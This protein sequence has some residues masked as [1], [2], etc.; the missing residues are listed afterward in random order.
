MGYGSFSPSEH[1]ALYV[2][3]CHTPTVT[4]MYKRVM[5]SNKASEDPAEKNLAGTHLIPPICTEL[6]NPFLSRLQKGRAYKH[7]V[8]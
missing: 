4:H 3:Q 8:H 2:M 6:H 7:W 5:I 1:T